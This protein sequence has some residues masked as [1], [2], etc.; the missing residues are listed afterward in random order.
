MLTEAFGQPVSVSVES[1]ATTTDDEAATELSH[2]ARA[3]LEP[4]FTDEPTE[5]DD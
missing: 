2:D 5:D 3:N 4:S 1:A